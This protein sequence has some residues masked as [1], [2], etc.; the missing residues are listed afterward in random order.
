MSGLPQ[1]LPVNSLCSGAFN[2]TQRDLSDIGTASQRQ[3]QIEGEDMEGKCK[4]VR[5]FFQ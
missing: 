1:L 2:I 3:R 5:Y 4:W